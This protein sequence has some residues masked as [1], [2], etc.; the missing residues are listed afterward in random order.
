MPLSNMEMIE[1][2]KRS[3][4]KRC[5]ERIAAAAKGSE[6]RTDYTTPRFG[7]SALLKH[8]HGM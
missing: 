2:L 5:E 6:G 3:A 7:A 4:L 1:K 8:R